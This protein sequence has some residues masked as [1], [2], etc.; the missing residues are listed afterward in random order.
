MSNTSCNESAIRQTTISSRVPISGGTIVSPTLIESENC[1]KYLAAMRKYGV[2][3]YNPT[4][5]V[6]I[7]TQDDDAIA[8]LKRST[9]QNFDKTLLSAIRNFTTK[10]PNASDTQICDEFEKAKSKAPKFI[11]N[12]NTE[13]SK[14]L[15]NGVNIIKSTRQDGIYWSALAQVLSDSGRTDDYISYLSNQKKPVAISTEVVAGKYLP[16][17]QLELLKA[18]I[19]NVKES[20]DRVTRS[21]QNTLREIRNL[22]AQN[23]VL[24]V[25][26][27]ELDR[28]G[29]PTG[30]QKTVLLEVPAGI[31]LKNVQ[32]LP[33]NERNAVLDRIRKE[34]KPLRTPFDPEILSSDGINDNDLKNY[35]EVTDRFTQISSD[36]N[37]LSSFYSTEE[38][39]VRVGLSRQNTE[40]VARIN[41]ISRGT[42]TETDLEIVNNGGFSLGIKELGK[43][44]GSNPTFGVLADAISK[45]V[46]YVN[47]PTSYIVGAEVAVNGIAHVMEA[48][49]KAELE[50]STTLLQYN[51][52]RSVIN[53]NTSAISTRAGIGLTT[54]GQP[55]RTLIKSQIDDI[56][57]EHLHHITHTGH[58][59][60]H[61]LPWL[62][63]VHYGI[64]L[65]VGSDGLTI[66][67]NSLIMSA[68]NT[69]KYLIA[70]DA[71]KAGKYA[72]KSL[73][74]G[75]LTTIE[76]LAA[77]GMIGGGP[78]LGLAAGVY[79]LYEVGEISAK[80][81]DSYDRRALG[82]EANLVESAYEYGV[83]IPYE[84]LVA[85]V[86]T[87]DDDPKNDVF[88]HRKG[89]PVL[90]TITATGV[91]GGS[92][93][94][95][96]R[97]VT[98]KVPIVPINILDNSTSVIINK[99]GE[100]KNSKEIRESKER[101]ECCGPCENGI[102]REVTTDPASLSPYCLEIF[103]KYG[104]QAISRGIISTDPVQ[105]GI[106]YLCNFFGNACFTSDTI[107]MT[108]NGEK[109]IDEFSKGDQVIAFDENGNLV[110]SFVT[111]L[112]VHNNESVYSYIFSNGVSIKS[113]PNHPFY[114]RNGFV[115]IG[116]L[117]VGDT[118]I[119][120]NNNEI[121]LISVENIGQHI[122]YN[123]EVD[124]HHTYIANGIRV[125]NKFDPNAAA[126]AI[127]NR[128]PESQ[129]IHETG[130]NWPT[131]PSNENWDTNPARWNIQ[132]I[133][134]FRETNPLN[135]L[136]SGKGDWACELIL[137]RTFM[138]S[139]NEGPFGTNT[140]GYESSDLVNGA[141]LPIP[142]T[143]TTN[144][145]E[146]QGPPYTYVS[147]PS[148]PYFFI[149]PSNIETYLK[150]FPYYLTDSETKLVKS[151]DLEEIKSYFDTTG[152]DPNDR[153]NLKSYH[154]VLISQRYTEEIEKEE[155]N[156]NERRMYLDC[157]TS[158]MG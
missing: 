73:K 117:K 66:T 32:N 16:N 85:A 130:N 28:N 18:E 43:E 6:L 70:G 55:V 54:E 50:K 2:L 29:N 60:A 5:P 33:E 42:P 27:E 25:E 90:T 65:N 44:V 11:F 76:V 156:I 72:G 68:F 116:N 48:S 64:G 113:T 71:D 103:N 147:Q 91:V 119:D 57:A 133:C 132:F 153:N 51:N 118:V 87:A 89:K 9:N 78:A 95:R 31:N 21:V 152:K 124:E 59:I 100:Q 52:T 61:A 86:S 137:G 38:S 30:R 139:I 122:V 79:F 125:H 17:A 36:P 19:Q 41:R 157:I 149:K 109:K 75:A 145:L 141:G 131:P 56:A 84:S 142:P 22:Y 120:S 80:R 111:D 106:N 37:L 107:I 104:Q 110:E 15:M 134:R 20:F 10:N 135:P 143:Q 97:T 93:R 74:Y 105:S 127:S 92:A 129:P 101:C 4:S 67:D 112:F 58:K 140:S 155:R 96:A 13:V 14:I 115:E 98:G 81:K 150:G 88:V 144:K 26:S 126:E 114:T 35:K 108:P 158:I 99:D 39:V 53:G 138:P 136:P 123:I 40:T 46:G 148:N 3:T 83:V 8:K 146:Y 94:R 121:S 47:K 62:G 154:L 102:L 23:R 69:G 77:L 45:G 34:S 24:P 7:S 128:P 82:R 1:N 63:A 12:S 151:G 49:L